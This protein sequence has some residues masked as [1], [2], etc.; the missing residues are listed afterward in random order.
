MLSKWKILRLAEMTLTGTFWWNTHFIF[1]SHP[2]YKKVKKKKKVK[3]SKKQLSTFK[4]FSLI[5]ST[6][7]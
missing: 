3:R 4:F 7:I 1:F 6:A 2:S 5:N